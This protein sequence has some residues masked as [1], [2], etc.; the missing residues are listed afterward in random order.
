MRVLKLMVAA[1]IILSLI[2]AGFFIAQIITI[3]DALKEENVCALE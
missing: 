3:R 2:A 1:V